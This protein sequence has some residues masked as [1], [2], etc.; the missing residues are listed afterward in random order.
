MFTRSRA[1]L[2]HMIEGVH[3]TVAMLCANTIGSLRVGCARAARAMRH[4]PLHAIHGSYPEELT[5]D[6]IAYIYQLAED[7]RRAR[8]QKLGGLNQQV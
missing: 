2:H 7:R 5:E 8:N 3:H 6:Q 4:E 1:T